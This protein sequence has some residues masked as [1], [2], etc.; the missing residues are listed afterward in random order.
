MTIGGQFFERWG[1]ACRPAGE[2]AGSYGSQ[3]GARLLCIWD[4]DELGA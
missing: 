3:G 1:Y 2:P 4:E